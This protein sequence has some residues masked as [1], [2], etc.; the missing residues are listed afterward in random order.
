[1]TLRYDEALQGD[2][3]RVY[4]MSDALKAWLE[5]NIR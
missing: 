1:V 5:A 4:A 3:W 2:G